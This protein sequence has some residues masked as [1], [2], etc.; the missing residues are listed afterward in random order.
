MAVN[1]IHK[2]ST[3]LYH[4]FKPA[5]IGSPVKPHKFSLWSFQL[6]PPMT[7][8]FFL[9]EIIIDIFLTSLYNNN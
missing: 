7:H 8:N 3:I 6:Y 5:S 1:F 4:F 9:Y 2:Y